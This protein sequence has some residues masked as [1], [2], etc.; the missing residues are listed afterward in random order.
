MFRKKN[1]RHDAYWVRIPATNGPMAE[2]VSPKKSSVRMIITPDMATTTHHF[3]VASSPPVRAC[4]AAGTGLVTGREA[5]GSAS[6]AGGHEPLEALRHEVL[7]RR[8][9]RVFLEQG[10]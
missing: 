8:S 1:H 10:S 3:R 7:L 6:R 5:T 2:P 4:G 9:D